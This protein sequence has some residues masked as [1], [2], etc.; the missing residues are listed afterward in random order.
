VTDRPTTRWHRVNTAS[1]LNEMAGN[2]R[3]TL[4]GRQRPDVQTRQWWTLQ[5]T[6]DDGRV[7][8]TVEASSL[9]LLLKR[10]AAMEMDVEERQ[11]RAEE[12]ENG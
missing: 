10:A 2:G 12:E 9:T 6:A 7:V 11:E 1:F 3:I 8:C 5:W 4:E